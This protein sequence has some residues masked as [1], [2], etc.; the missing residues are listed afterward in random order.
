ML[1]FPLD[2]MNRLNKTESAVFLYCRFSLFL[3]ESFFQIICFEIFKAQLCI[4]ARI[5]EIIDLIN[6]GFLLMLRLRT[7]V[8]LINNYA[9]NKFIHY[10]LDK[11]YQSFTSN[12]L[13]Y[14]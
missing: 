6:M 8:W 10:F 7:M 13:I 1:H 12:G 5:G 4:G 14:S 11:L 9:D 3:K 2:F